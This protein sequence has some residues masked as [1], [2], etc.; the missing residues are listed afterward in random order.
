MGGKQHD[1]PAP[2]T[3][4]SERLSGG[5]LT[6]RVVLAM[7]K[8]WASTAGNPPSTCCHTA[9][10]ERGTIEHAQQLAGH[11]SPRTMKLYDRTP[12]TVTVDKDRPYRDRNGAAAEDA[13]RPTATCSGASAFRSGTGNAARM[14]QHA[15]GRPDRPGSHPPSACWRRSCPV[16]Q[17]L[18]ER[19]HDPPPGGQT[20][21]AADTPI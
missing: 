10:V 16:A 6:R 7:I 2:P 3:G 8:R 12:H 11:A 19:G 15:T 5:P 20:S 1:F 18:Q 9:Y 13:P 17:A 14:P 21:Q 4:A